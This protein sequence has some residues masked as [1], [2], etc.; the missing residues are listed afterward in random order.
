ML[1]TSGQWPV[2]VTQTTTLAQGFRAVLLTPLL[3]PNV[4]H[5][6]HQ[7]QVAAG[8][9]LP[10]LS[11]A[12]LIYTTATVDKHLDNSV[13]LHQVESVLKGRQKTQQQL[14]QRELRA[15]LVSGRASGHFQLDSAH[16]VA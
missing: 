11:E 12:M 8:V 7:V 9:L 1:V 16:A 13:Y 14:Q 10:P 2:S 5:V 4:S 3:A 6:G 15:G